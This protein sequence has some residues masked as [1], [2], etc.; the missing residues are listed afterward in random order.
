MVPLGEMVRFVTACLA[1]N[2][3]I[4]PTL[5]MHLGLFDERNI[6]EAMFIALTHRDHYLKQPQG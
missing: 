2:Y 6:K 4:D 3:R 1:V 5:A